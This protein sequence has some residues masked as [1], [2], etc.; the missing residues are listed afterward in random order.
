[1]S[2]IPQITYKVEPDTTKPGLFNLLITLPLVQSDNPS[3]KGFELSMEG[4]KPMDPFHDKIGFW[5]QLTEYSDDD[6]LFFYVAKRDP[7]YIE[8]VVQYIEENILGERYSHLTP[9]S[10]H[11]HFHTGSLGASLFGTQK[12]MIR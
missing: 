3:V 12:E 5:Y 8:E 10:I 6:H 2:S 1:M 7:R 9:K 11:E 4:F